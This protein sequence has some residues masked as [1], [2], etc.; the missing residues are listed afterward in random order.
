MR[1]H[2]KDHRLVH[3]LTIQTGAA[4]ARQDGNAFP[5]APLHYANG[6]VNIANNNSAERIDLERTSIRGINQP[7][8]AS[9]ANIR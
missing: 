6:F 5:R 3:A 7:L 1:A 8:R 9:S 2:I 4:A